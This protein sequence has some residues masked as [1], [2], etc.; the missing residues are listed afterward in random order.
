MI[1]F[2]L[3]W[4]FDTAIGLAASGGFILYLFRGPIEKNITAT[5][6]SALAILLATIM[7]AGW[8]KISNHAT[9]ALL[10]LAIEAAPGIVYLFLLTVIHLFGLKL[11]HA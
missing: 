2:K 4:L 6:L 11:K 10:L 5:W 9:T 3:L 7:G 1:L 8:L